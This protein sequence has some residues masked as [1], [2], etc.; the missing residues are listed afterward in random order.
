MLGNETSL[1]FPLPRTLAWTLGKSPTKNSEYPVTIVNL[2]ELWM[3]KLGE[4]QTAH[5]RR[6]PS[7]I[8]I[9]WC[10]KNKLAS[11]IA[12]WK[13][14]PFTCLPIPFH[15]PLY[16][17]SQTDLFFFFFFLLIISLDAL[18]WH[19]SLLI[20]KKMAYQKCWLWRALGGNKL[21]HQIWPSHPSQTSKLRQTNKN[22]VLSFRSP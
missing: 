1:F 12:K 2:P 16:L 15:H 9:R 22:L 7:K 13:V 19:W 11:G 4:T 20:N 8:R 3:I 18:E 5:R 6:Y 21:P 14:F 10:L 17:S